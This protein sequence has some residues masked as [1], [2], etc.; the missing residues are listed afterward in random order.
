MKFSVKDFSNK[1][2]RI[3][4]KLWIGSCLLKKSLMENFIFLCSATKKISRWTFSE[5][6]RLKIIMFA[7]R[8]ALTMWK[9]SKYGVFYSLNFS[10]YG[11]NTEIYYSVN[12]CVQSNYEKIRT[13]TNSISGKFFHNP[14][15]VICYTEKTTRVLHSNSSKYFYIIISVFLHTQF[16]HLTMDP[17]FIL[18][19]SILKN[20][21]YTER[22]CR[23]W[24]I[25]Y[26][27][28]HI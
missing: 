1:C 16:L 10:V 9:V 5:K 11:I 7:K 2:D 28:F 26:G 6:K 3:H 25:L 18:V 4:W 22:R 27:N 17:L 20:I 8:A 13:T 12:L 24:K 21:K 14:W 19:I 15:K 23:V